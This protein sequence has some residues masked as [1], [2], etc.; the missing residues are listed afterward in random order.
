MGYIYK[1]KI[2]TKTGTRSHPNAQHL[3]PLQHPQHCVVTVPAQRTQALV[4]AN[5]IYLAETG[6]CFTSAC[7]KDI[8]DKASFGSRDKD[9][10]GLF[11]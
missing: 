8:P 2:P 9:L 11:F 10:G 5:N 6:L 1:K 7:F 4:L 3:I